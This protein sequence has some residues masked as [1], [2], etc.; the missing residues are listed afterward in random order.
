M[1]EEAAQMSFQS[2]RMDSMEN[3]TETTKQSQFPTAYPMEDRY[4]TGSPTSQDQTFTPDDGLFQSQQRMTPSTV[5]STNIQAQSHMNSF[6]AQQQMFTESHPQPEQ[7]GFSASSHQSNNVQQQFFSEDKSNNQGQGRM[8]AGGDYMRNQQGYY[9]DRQHAQENRQFS[10]NRPQDF[11][12]APA[13]NKQVFGNVQLSAFDNREH[14]LVIPRLSHP[15][16]AVFVSGLKNLPSLPALVYNSG[17]FSAAQSGTPVTSL[18]PA[19]AFGSNTFA[20]VRAVTSSATVSSAALTPVHT[21]PYGYSTL[22]HDGSA[23]GHHLSTQYASVKQHVQTPYASVQQHL[24]TPY[25]SIK[26]H[27]QTP[28]VRYVYS[29]LL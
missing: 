11:H 4:V 1:Q 15:G 6:A 26:Q 27:F 19:Y 24:K 20:P 29:H 21:A 16:S 10:E 22:Y 23:S 8:L 28:H 13:E 3:P 17:S 2:N 18:T 9:A 25:A 7:H 5:S 14:P 12:G